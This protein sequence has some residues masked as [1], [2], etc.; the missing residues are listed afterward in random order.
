MCWTFNSLHLLDGVPNFVDTSSFGLGGLKNI[1]SLWPSCTLPLSLASV[2]NKFKPVLPLISEFITKSPLA[3]ILP[4]AVIW[5]ISKLPLPLILPEAVIS[6]TMKLPL[7]LI[8]PEAVIWPD[9]TSKVGSESPANI[10]T[11]I[12]PDCLPI[13]IESAEF[14]PKNKLPSGLR[15]KSSL[16][17]TVLKKVSPSNLKL[18]LK[19]FSPVPLEL[20]LPEAVIW[21]VVEIL[22]PTVSILSEPVASPTPIKT[23]SE[24]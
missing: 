22:P 8:L 13:W 21:D 3:L 14:C 16:E 2:G 20:I 18:P 7:A 1:V 17:P 23:F 24:E 5:L 10:L 6:L 9:F 4:E 15:Y 12:V 19:K 11:G